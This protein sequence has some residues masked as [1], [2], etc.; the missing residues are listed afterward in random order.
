MLLF[1]LPYVLLAWLLPLL[2]S[3]AT[4][5]PK[6]AREQ[7]AA[8]MESFVATILVPLAITFVFLF[9]HGLRESFRIAGP[10]Y[11]FRM[12]FQDLRALRIPSAVHLRN[13][14]YL[15]DTAA[16]FGATLKTLQAE[17]LRL[18]RL[19]RSASEELAR[20]QDAGGDAAAMQRAAQAVTSIEAA[21]A[22]FTLMG[23]APQNVP[24]EVD[25]RREDGPEERAMIVM[26]ENPTVPID[27]GAH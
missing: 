1:L 22:R 27:R 14:D 19:G 4:D 6:W 2:A 10:A 23:P 18:R 5:A 24:L 9:I 16:E 20:A 13:G 12:V 15:Q 25:N 21:V 7:T 8:Q 3:G 26:R 17:L 11:R